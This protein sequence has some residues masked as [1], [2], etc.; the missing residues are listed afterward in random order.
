MSL[1]CFIT[2]G[3]SKNHN[4]SNLFSSDDGETTLS[5][6]I[7]SK[8][9]NRGEKIKIIIRNITQD[10]VYYGGLGFNLEYYD[11]NKWN[12]IL[13]NEGEGN[14]PYLLK[15]IEYGEPLELETVLSSDIYSFDFV[16]G[17]YRVVYDEWYGEFIIS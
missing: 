11:N 14:I 4:E 1:I 6:E 17:R 5:I 12:V 16:P 2:V 10:S 13:F 9:I 15:R 3:C 7:E 8:N